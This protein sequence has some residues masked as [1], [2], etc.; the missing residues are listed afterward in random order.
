MFCFSI[1]YG[2]KFDEVVCIQGI[3]AVLLV[4]PSNVCSVLLQAMKVLCF[5]LK[6]HTAT[7]G[8]IS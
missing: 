7:F 5:A 1:P 2:C 4:K 8:V 6:G 3:L